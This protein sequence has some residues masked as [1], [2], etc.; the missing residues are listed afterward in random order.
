MANLNGQNFRILRLNTTTGKFE[1]VGMATNCTVNLN[2]NTSDQSTKDDV[3]LA[4]KPG[5]NSKNWSVNVDSLSVSDVGAILTAMKDNTPF[6]LVWDEVS[7]SDNQSPVASTAFA[8]KGTAYLNDATFS[9][10]TRTFASKQLQFT[11]SGPLETLSETPT[12]E[13]ISAGSYTKGETVRLFLST[14]NTTTP[15]SVIAF[16][17]TL[18]L[19]VSVQLESSATKDTEGDWDIQVPTGISYDLS[20]SALMRSG[21]TITS[22]VAGQT[23][24]ELESIYAASSPAKWLIA[25][26]S[27]ANHRTKGS[28]IVSGSAILA[29]LTLNAPNR[30]TAS[31]NASLNGWGPYT[32]GA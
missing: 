6:T 32:V 22:A 16:A 1:V 14:D 20:T 2:T 4:A 31:Y 12:A 26:T 8:R 9:F 17:R 30:Q 18:S 10:D 24:A 13:A 5:I 25:N 27:G 19:H 7:T 15:S 28:V 29:S 23:I 21:E 3:S 11:G